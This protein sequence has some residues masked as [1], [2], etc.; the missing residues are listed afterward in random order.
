MKMD[1]QVTIIINLMVKNKY[2][3]FGLFNVSI[4]KY[5][6]AQNIFNICITAI[7]PQDILCNV[8]M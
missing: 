5:T 6:N 3:D 8:A 2:F 4:Q 1:L 7:S